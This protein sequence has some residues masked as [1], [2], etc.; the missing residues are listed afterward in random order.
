MDIEFNGR[1][2][3][4]TSFELKNLPNLTIIT[5][6]N[7][8]GKSQLL[9]LLNYQYYTQDKNN[10][11]VIT[12][13]IKNKIL[14]KSH[15]SLSHLESINLL[16]LQD[17]LTNYST[18]NNFAPQSHI[19][20][21]KARFGKQGILGIRNQKIDI[22]ELL[23]DFSYQKFFNNYQ[24]DIREPNLGLEVLFFVYYY[25]Y[26]L[27]K[28]NY[29]NENKNTN[30][31]EIVQDLGTPPWDIVNEFLEMINSPYK[32]NNPIE[33]LGNNI[34]GQ[35]NPAFIDKK[36]GIKITSLS[37]L[38]S[39]ENIMVSLAFWLYAARNQNIFPDLIL[40]DEPDA[41]LHPEFIKQFLNILEKI[42][43]KYNTHIIM[44]THSPVTIALA[45]PNSVYEMQKHDTPRIIQSKSVLSSI[46]MLCSG[47]LVFQPNKK[48][49]ITEDKTDS[50]TYTA[51]YKILIRRK[52]IKDDTQLVFL[53]I[54]NWSTNSTGGKNKVIE[55]VNK[56]QDIN[57]D[58]GIVVNG[59]LDYDN[60]SAT[61]NNSNIK[62]INR[63]SIENYLLDPINIFASI[64]KIYNIDNIPITVGEEGNIKNLEQEQLQLIVDKICSEIIKKM[65]VEKQ[66]ENVTR[67]IKYINE[68]EIRCPKW[69]FNTNGHD[70]LVYCQNAFTGGNK[71]IYHDNLIN[72]LKR[73]Q[74]VSEDFIQL[75]NDIIDSNISCNVS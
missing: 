2:K 74:M 29:A 73:T 66:T 58:N 5:G 7:G 12:P 35:Y 55:F 22:N 70:L 61:L 13:E 33:E 45:Q 28:M 52:L 62:Y 4:V 6:R 26:V 67:T 17:I 53:P 40:L 38:S 20:K 68:K 64:L 49:I 24:N 60:G 32:I 46:N 44:T 10:K 59:L 51:I 36:R 34:I 37:N 23:G 43:R 8:A 21:L 42:C 9:E 54:S 30:D 14:L 15:F 18:N 39:G 57:K 31:K 25:Q 47:L 41:H 75:F 72:N 11:I 50:K 19:D 65:P 63:Y 27:K 71:I 56:I 16:K 3:A 1:Y 48:Y 69:L